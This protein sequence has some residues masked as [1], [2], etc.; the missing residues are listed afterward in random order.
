M[1]GLRVKELVLKIM[2]AAIE[3]T[4]CTSNDVFVN[5]EGHVMILDVRV[6]SGDKR[7]FDKYLYLSPPFEGYKPEVPVLEELNCILDYINAL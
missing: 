5:F 1:E 4:V 6:Y 3:K 2:N 7:I